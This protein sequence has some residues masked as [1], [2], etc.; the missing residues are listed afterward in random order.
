M[1]DLRITDD[2]E[3]AQTGAIVWFL[4]LKLTE[5][6]SAAAGRVQSQTILSPVEWKLTQIQALTHDTFHAWARLICLVLYL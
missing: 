2:S 3:T 1:V 6:S 5:L 4:W